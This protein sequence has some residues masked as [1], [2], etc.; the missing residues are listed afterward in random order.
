M[1]TGVVGKLFTFTFNDH[2]YNRDLGIFN[3]GGGAL[4]RVSCFLIDQLE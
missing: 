1:P 2:V 4:D 3:Y